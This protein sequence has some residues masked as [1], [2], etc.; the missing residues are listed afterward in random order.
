VVAC[1]QASKRVVT[2]WA[3]RWISVHGAGENAD[4]RVSPSGT[5]LPAQPPRKPPKHTI[6]TGLMA[7]CVRLWFLQLRLSFM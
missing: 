3:Q 1:A 4:A 2:L 5:S 6:R 7:P